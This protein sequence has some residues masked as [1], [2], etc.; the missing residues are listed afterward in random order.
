MADALSYYCLCH[1]RPAY[2]PT[3]PD[4]PVLAFDHPDEKFDAQ[5]RPPLT[6]N[7]LGKRTLLR[8]IGDYDQRIADNIPR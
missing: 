6:E 5:D 3:V 1:R 7:V 8:C 2:V 4:P